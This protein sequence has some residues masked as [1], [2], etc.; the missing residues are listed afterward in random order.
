MLFRSGEHPLG[1][2]RWEKGGGSLAVGETAH[3]S[4]SFKRVGF[5]ATRV[6]VRPLGSES[7][8]ALFSPGWKGDGEVLLKGGKRLLWKST[9]FWKAD[10]PLTDEA[11]NIVLSSH[12]SGSIT[13]QTATVTLGPHA[14][15]PATL[16]MLVIL[17]MYVGVLAMSDDA[18]TA[19][20]V[21]VLVAVSS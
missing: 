12:A 17:A 7:E 20:M 10:Y 1:H 11:G 19:A 15:D 9:S 3:G 21:A 16:S 18:D 14:V 13:P 4:W 6:S 8:I 2:L 5:F